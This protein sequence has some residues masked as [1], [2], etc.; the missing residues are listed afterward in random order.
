[1]LS[2]P[3]QYR[4]TNKKLGIFLII[5]I[6]NSIITSTGLIEKINNIYLVKFIL[7]IT[8]MYLCFIIFNFLLRLYNMFY[9]CIIFFKEKIKTKNIGIETI[10][11]YYFFNF[12]YLIL[13]VFIIYKFIIILDLYD[14]NIEN[15]F[16]FLFFIY[17]LSF[18]IIYISHTSGKEIEIKNI[19]LNNLSYLVIPFN[20]IIFINVIIITSKKILDLDIDMEFISNILKNQ[21]NLDLNISCMLEPHF[22]N[23]NNLNKEDNMSLVKTQSSISSNK[24]SNHNLYPLNEEELLQMQI[25]ENSQVVSNLPKN[26]QLI[27]KLITPEI[28]DPCATSTLNNLNPFINLEGDLLNTQN[29]LFQHSNMLKN[30]RFE[31]FLDRNFQNNI[32]NQKIETWQAENIVGKL[33]IDSPI[34]HSIIKGQDIILSWFYPHLTHEEKLKEIYEY[35]FYWQINTDLTVAVLHLQQQQEIDRINKLILNYNHLDFYKKLKFHPLYAKN[36]Y[37]LV[38]TI[39][40]KEIIHK[41]GSTEKIRYVQ[42]LPAK[43]NNGLRKVEDYLRIIDAIQREEEKKKIFVKINGT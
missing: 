29:L 37:N 5:L 11:I 18:S 17:F 4:I 38:K 19:E 43:P 15:V 33:P 36:P 31:E 16:L 12:F 25:S 26:I 27:S 20:L 3:S 41:D 22:S 9:K 7:I 35:Y 14:N 6:L 23:L 40:E 39:I 42:Y 1:M 21:K 13:N 34:L 8:F 28:S 32:L 2:L 24:E 10:I 30:I